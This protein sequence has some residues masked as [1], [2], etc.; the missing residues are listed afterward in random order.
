MKQVKLPNPENFEVLVAVGTLEG[1]SRRVVTVGVYIPPGYSTA[2]GRACMRYVADSIT[3]MKRRYREPTILIAGDFNQWGIQ[4]YL[5][6]F[7]D[8][9]EVDV[10]PTRGQSSID[11][12]FTNAASLVKRGGTVPPLDS[13]DSETGVDSDHRVAFARIELKKCRTFE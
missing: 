6:D 5:A 10:G 3:E 2:Q 9:G 1:H 13:K 12:I 4:D 8:I 11:R 7:V